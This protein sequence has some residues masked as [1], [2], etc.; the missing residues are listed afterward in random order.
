MIFALGLLALLQIAVL[1]GMLLTRHISVGFGL[2]RAFLIF[3]GSLLANY[4]LVALLVACHQYHQRSVMAVI[5]LEVLLLLYQRWRGG[6]DVV[7]T[8]E[9]TP[10]LDAAFASRGWQT[11]G[12]LTTAGVLV[13]FGVKWYH[14]WGA[15]FESYD[16][17]ASW[18]RWALEWSA[19]HWP[20]LTWNYPQLLPANWSLAYVITGAR[21]GELFA[22]CLMGAFP[23]LILLA[24]LELQRRLREPW[25]AVGAIAASTMLSRCFWGTQFDGYADVPVAA[26][27]FAGISFQLLAREGLRPRH[28]LLAAALCYGT[29]CVTK[30]AGLITT[31]C[32]I[33]WLFTDGRPRSAF[34]ECGSRGKLAL[35]LLI[36]VGLHWYVIHSVVSA[37]HLGSKDGEDL[38]LI[39]VLTV[40][41]HKGRN[42]LERAEFG[43]H[44]LAAHLQPAALWASLA[45]LL[46]AAVW[47]PR[48]VRV[49]GYFVLPALVVWLLGF[50]YDIRNLA[51]G[52]PP[53]CLA[54][55]FGAEALAKRFSSKR[56]RLSAAA[57]A[58]QVSASRSRAVGVAFLAGAAAILLMGAWWMPNEKLRGH[59]LKARRHAGSY[60][61]NKLIAEKAGAK[62]RVLT[63]YLQLTIQPS[64]TKR[65]TYLATPLQND[66]LEE[67]LRTYPWIVMEDKLSD[68]QEAVRA[69]LQEQKTIEE[70]GRE[71]GFVLYKN[72]GAGGKPLDKGSPPAHS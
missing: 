53:A 56:E 4:T 55:G 51:A 48:G 1:P 10:P 67:R 49:V 57:F 36:L 50:S 64:F 29:A 15:V 69:R 47:H 44:L 34:K 30:Q 71:G 42:L 60:R 20:N 18:N 23:A 9:R 28:S 58:P 38:H 8:A 39:Q 5:V 26:L 21:E 3:A 16:A 43:L 45:L 22:R 46:V 17:I 41:I 65:V 66:G 11:A 35:V 33:V 27:G 54:M 2:S 24:I 37:L 72:T 62:D 52:I 7:E 6:N 40:H 70:R 12:F 59:F 31:T 14:E 61:L 19:N 13:L 63:S 32:G 68:E 25:L